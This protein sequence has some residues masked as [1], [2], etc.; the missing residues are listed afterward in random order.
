MNGYLI[1]T[2]RN[3]FNAVTSETVSETN[4][5]TTANVDEAVEVNT[6]HHK[7]RSYS[8]I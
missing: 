5:F 6:F 2:V 7:N 1:L 8:N 3:C 4:F